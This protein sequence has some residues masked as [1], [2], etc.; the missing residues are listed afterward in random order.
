MADRLD[1]ADRNIPSMSCTPRTPYIHTKWSY[2]PG[3]LMFGGMFWAIMLAFGISGYITVKAI[4]HR[5]N[6]VFGF[7]MYCF[8]GSLV[9]AV[10]G[11]LFG[12]A[13]G[14]DAWIYCKQLLQ[15]ISGLIDQALSSSENTSSPLTLSRCR[16][17]DWPWPDP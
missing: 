15:A 11:V 13:V 1:L 8:L 4:K 6:T 7:V 3:G 16:V 14:V 2:I 17:S 12:K 5:S 10:G 9:L